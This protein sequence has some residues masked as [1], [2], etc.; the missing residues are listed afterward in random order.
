MA[1]SDNN[2]TIRRQCTSVIDCVCVS[3]CVCRF[4]IQFLAHSQLG[5]LLWRD[6]RQE[7]NIKEWGDCEDT[8]AKAGAKTVDTD[9]GGSYCFNLQ[10]PPVTRVLS[11]Y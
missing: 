1:R 6:T 3:V 4:L 5:L 7:A 11:I 9:R 10:A 2:Q 8:G